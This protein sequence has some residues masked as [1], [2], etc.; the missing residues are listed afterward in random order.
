MILLLLH[1]GLIVLSGMVSGAKRKTQNKTPPVQPPS[2]YQS[3]SEQFRDY[4]CWP[5]FWWSRCQWDVGGSGGFGEEDSGEVVGGM[6]PSLYHSKHWLNPLCGLPPRMQL[7][8]FD[9]NYEIL[10]S[11]IEK[12]EWNL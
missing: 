2:L 3:L 12:F 10:L 4:P 5:E 7:L 8:M 6:G 11:H 1:N 9:I